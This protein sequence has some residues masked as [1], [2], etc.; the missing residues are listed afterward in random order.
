MVHGAVRSQTDRTAFR[1]YL[2]HC[3]YHHPLYR[4]A[5]RPYPY[6]RLRTH[7]H[8]PASV[9]TDR[10]R[11]VVASS[12]PTFCPLLDDWTCSGL[13]SSLLV[14]Q[15]DL[16]RFSPYI[17][18]M[19]IPFLIGFLIVRGSQTLPPLPA[20]PLVPFPM[21]GERILLP[22]THLVLSNSQF[23]PAATPAVSFFW[24]KGFF[25]VLLLPHQFSYACIF[26][27]Q[28][29]AFA[30]LLLFVLNS[31]PTHILLLYTLAVIPRSVGTEKR[32]IPYTIRALIIWT[33]KKRRRKVWVVG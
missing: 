11:Q 4:F 28:Q 14:F 25:P 31:V 33:R 19:Y 26:Y 16:P 17:Y 15:H 8:L 3:P 27:D 13:V 2:T 24:R 1:H 32:T 7:Y 5:A 12:P 21:P 18:P 9:R 22:S 10:R 30:F 6:H 20:L 23:S 29:H